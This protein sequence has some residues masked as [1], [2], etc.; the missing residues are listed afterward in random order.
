MATDTDGVNLLDLLGL[1]PNRPSTTLGRRAGSRIRL[2]HASS[3]IAP[4]PRPAENSRRF[5]SHT[6]HEA[7]EDEAARVRPGNDVRVVDN[8]TRGVLIESPRQLNT[9][10]RVEISIVVADTRDR[11]DLTGAVRRCH[12]SCLSPLTYHGA[13]EFESEI[14][15]RMLEPFIAPSARTA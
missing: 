5:E 7:H 11:V 13:V 6:P 2:L 14:E 8:G 12:V 1:N 3:G 9:G 10:M 15:L 4:A